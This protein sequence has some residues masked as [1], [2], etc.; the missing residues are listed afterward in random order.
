MNE[1]DIENITYFGN[2]LI[3]YEWV[4][5]INQLWNGIALILSNSDGFL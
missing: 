3:G 2:I 4:F 1:N 5:K